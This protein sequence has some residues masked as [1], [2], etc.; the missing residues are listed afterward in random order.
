M[1]ACILCRQRPSDRAHHSSKE[2]CQIS[3]RLEQTRQP[4]PSRKKE[5]GGQEEMLINKMSDYL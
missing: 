2:P 5:K 3:V 4:N 1:S